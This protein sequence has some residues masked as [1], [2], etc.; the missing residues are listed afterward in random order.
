MPR[1][2]L[3]LFAVRRRRRCWTAASRRTA[4][5]RR[6]R[7]AI[8]RR[9]SSCSAAMST[10]APPQA[11]TWCVSCLAS[12]AV[13]TCNQSAWLLPGKLLSKKPLSRHVRRP[14]GSF[15]G[16]LC[17]QNCVSKFVYGLVLEERERFTSL[18]EVKYVL[19]LKQARRIG[20]S[21]CSQCTPA[22]R[23]WAWCRR[24]RRPHGS[25]ATA[26]CPG[27]AASQPSAGWT[28]RRRPRTWLPPSRQRLPAAAHVWVCPRML[29]ACC[30]TF[31]AIPLLAGNHKRCLSDATLGMQASGNALLIS[32]SRS[33]MGLVSTLNPK[34]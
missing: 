16:T 33:C 29:H 21:S 19:F 27:S 25:C 18:L 34:P 26:S 13:L 1:T 17:R 12:G 28:P 10:S 20:W 3:L 32:P 8:A 14:A 11:P 23:R 30:N 7:S 9:C 15:C 31:A 2:D 22:P 6:A 5:A 4:A 24:C